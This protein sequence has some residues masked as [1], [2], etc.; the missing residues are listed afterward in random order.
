[1]S[2]MHGENRMEPR[3]KIE[4]KHWDDA[5]TFSEEMKHSFE[6]VRMMLDRVK[7]DGRIIYANYDEIIEKFGPYVLVA[8]KKWWEEKE[9]QEK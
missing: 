9:S 7:Y 2:L 5:E 4:Q 8:A 6:G 1:M 3:L